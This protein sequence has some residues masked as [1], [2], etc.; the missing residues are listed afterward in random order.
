MAKADK[1][2]VILSEPRLQIPLKVKKGPGTALGKRINPPNQK[3]RG[4]QGLYQRSS[5]NVE[6]AETIR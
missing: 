3:G 6:H 5:T 1:F 2:Q 4:G